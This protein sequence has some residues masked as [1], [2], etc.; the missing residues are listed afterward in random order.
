MKKQNSMQRKNKDPNIGFK[1]SNSSF[2]RQTNITLHATHL[3]LFMP[4]LP[5]KDHG[6]QRLHP[7]LKVTS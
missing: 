3:T 7:P 6:K 2:Y 1:D 5:Q 4:H